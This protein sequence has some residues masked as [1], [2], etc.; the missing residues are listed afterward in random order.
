MSELSKGNVR[1]HG[2]FFLPNSYDQVL[3]PESIESVALDRCEPE[4]ER[5]LRA[6]AQ[7]VGIGVLR[8]SAGDVGRF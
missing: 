7:Q 5:E 8:R 6:F 2:T 1:V 4:L 3:S